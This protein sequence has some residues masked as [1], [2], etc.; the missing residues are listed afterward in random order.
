MKLRFNFK[1]KEASLE[2]DAE[3]LIEKK[4]D[5]KQENTKRFGLK[6]TRYQIRQ[7]EKRKNKELEHKHNM[8][9]LIICF[10][11]LA[12]LIALCMIMPFATGA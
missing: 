7:E 4:M 11:I 2:A 5:Y 12:V 3:K 6:K 10:I 9:L 1:N 8:Q